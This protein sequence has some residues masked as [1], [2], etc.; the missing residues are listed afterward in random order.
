MVCLGFEPGP[1]DGMCRPIRLAM[2][3]PKTQ[4]DPEFHWLRQIATTLPKFH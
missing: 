3:A 1:Q 4:L 2:A